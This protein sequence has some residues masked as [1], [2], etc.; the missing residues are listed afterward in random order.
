MMR[1]ISLRDTILLKGDVLLVQI[2][3]KDIVKFKD[4]LELLML[5]D[6]KMSQDELAGK[7]HVFVVNM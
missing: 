1:S 3:L 7:N 5:S 4:D 2:N 6:V